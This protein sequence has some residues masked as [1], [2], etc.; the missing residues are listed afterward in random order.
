MKKSMLII[1]TGH[2][3]TLTELSST[4]VCS[5]GDVFRTGFILPIFS[6]YHIDWLIDSKSSTL[7]GHYSNIN[8]INMED[9]STLNLEK[10]DL[11]LNLEKD[12]QVLE[13]VSFLEQTKGFVLN[14][15]ELYINAFNSDAKLRFENYD[16]GESKSFQSKILGMLNLKVSEI[17]NKIELAEENENLYKIGFNWKV[18]PKW[19]EKALPE[20]FWKELEQ[21]LQGQ[22]SLSWQEGFNDINCYLKWIN[23]C[24]TIITLDS[25]GLHLAVA[26][27]KQVISLFGPT[28][29]DEVELFDRGVKFSYKTEEE[30][31]MLIDKICEHLL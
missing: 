17:D 4:E 11:I 15:G 23:S 29:S 18:G 19:P 20:S 10:Y 28:N 6:D 2:A 31:N 13:Q 26:L 1:K 12:T 5:L 14:H 21:R 16:F 7:L 3:E 8:T 24:E 30:K 22:L 27:N 9:F 25:L